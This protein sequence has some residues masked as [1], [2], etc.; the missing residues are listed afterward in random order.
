MLV[1][2]I[3]L[4]NISQTAFYS[5]YVPVL[6]LFVSPLKQAILRSASVFTLRSPP[7]ITSSALSTPNQPSHANR[8]RQL[9]DII[10]QIRGT[11]LSYKA[12]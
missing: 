10:Q 2:L 7:L 3:Q 9:N 4:Y 6:P 5:T 1:G 11:H 12:G 8:F